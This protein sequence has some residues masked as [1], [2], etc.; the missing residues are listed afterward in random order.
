MPLTGFDPLDNFKERG[1]D[2]AAYRYLIELLNGCRPKVTLDDI[3]DKIASISKIETDITIEGDKWN[4]SLYEE[5]R[6][7]IIQHQRAEKFLNHLWGTYALKESL[8]RSLCR[9]Q[10]VSTD[11]EHYR[12]IGKNR[13]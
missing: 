11:L 9:I 8:L 2:H 13:Q 12:S 4:K 10:E 3:E 7:M 1:E 5:L 6:E